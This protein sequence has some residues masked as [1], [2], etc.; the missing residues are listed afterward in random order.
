MRYTVKINRQASRDLIEIFKYIEDFFR[1]KC[2]L[3]LSLAT[4]KTY[5]FNTER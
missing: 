2:L 5:A 1:A 3:T 4:R